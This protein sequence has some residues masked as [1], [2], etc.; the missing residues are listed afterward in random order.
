VRALARASV[1]LEI[2]ILSGRRRRLRVPRGDG[3][4]SGAPRGQAS[5]S[6]DRTAPSERAGRHLVEPAKL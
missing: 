2:Q 1:A 4:A 5:R 6:P 3:E